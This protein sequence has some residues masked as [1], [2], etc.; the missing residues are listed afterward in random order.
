MS[1]KIREA[2]KA[3]VGAL[4]AGLGVI[5]A[6]LATGD[7]TTATYVAAAVAALIAFEGVYWTSN[8]DTT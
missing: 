5:A 4:I 2:A 1:D 6:A 7:A 8:G 3:I